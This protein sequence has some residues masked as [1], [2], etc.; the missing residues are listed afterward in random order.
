MWL[1]WPVFGTFSMGGAPG[2]REHLG[3]AY[4]EARPFRSVL[5]GRRPCCR[6]PFRVADVPERVCARGDGC[7]GLAWPMLDTALVGADTMFRFVSELVV[8][9]AMRGPG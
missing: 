5:A 8:T 9:K 3:S 2:P 7:V 6:A 1:P 4:H